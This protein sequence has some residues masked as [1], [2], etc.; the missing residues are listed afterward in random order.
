ME[1][2]SQLYATNDNIIVYVPKVKET[3]ESGIVKGDAVVREEAKKLNQNNSLEV[4]DVGPLCQ[5]QNVDPGDTVYIDGKVV[6]L[7]HP[8]EKEGFEF[9]VIK[10][11]AVL[12]TFKTDL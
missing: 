10:S 6:L 1:T 2:G 4:Y 8:C 12:A 5:D 9:G 11:Y 7:A 3:T